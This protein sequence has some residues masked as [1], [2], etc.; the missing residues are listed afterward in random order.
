MRHAP[1]TI[2]RV[3]ALAERQRV[4]GVTLLPLIETAGLVER[5]IQPAAVLIRSFVAPGLLVRSPR[6]PVAIAAGGF[7]LVSRAAYEGVGGTRRCGTS[8]WTTRCWRYG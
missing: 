8:S 5:M 3:L 2:A 4:A 1:D 7:I 6:S